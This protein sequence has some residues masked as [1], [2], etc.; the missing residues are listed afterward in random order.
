[1]SVFVEKTSERITTV[2]GGGGF[3]ELGSTKRFV[4][5]GAP[6]CAAVLTLSPDRVVRTQPHKEAV[7]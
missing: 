4:A 3:W 6:C 2:G 7:T 5:L 1:M